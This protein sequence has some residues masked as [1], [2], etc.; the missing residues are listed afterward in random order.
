MYAEAHEGDCHCPRCAPS[1]PRE[2]AQRLADQL[3][4]VS[5]NELHLLAAGPLDVTSP[6]TLDAWLALP[7]N[8][9]RTI[10]EF[11]EAVGR[12]VAIPTPISVVPQNPRMRISW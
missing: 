7:P 9:S 2:R 10:E 6:A 8:D 12:P 5:L 1:R 11:F 3:R 4:S